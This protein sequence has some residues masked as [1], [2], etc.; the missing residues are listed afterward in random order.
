MVTELYGLPGAGKTTIIKNFTDGRATTVS[1]SK[2]LKRYIIQIAKKIVVYLPSSIQYKRRMNTIMK[3]YSEKSI[4]INRPKKQ[5]YNNIVMV[6]FGYK[7]MGNAVYMDEGL[8][9]RIITMAVNFG[10]TEDDVLA[11]IDLFEPCMR[12]VRSFYLDV[13]AEECLRS[14]MARDRHECE[15]DEFNKDTL[16]KYLRDYECYCLAICKSYQH[17]VIT[18]ENYE[19]MR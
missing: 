6:A 10:L 18:R 17:K 8:I 13:P 5:Y 3:S 16:K 2:G 11:L 9:H 7:N 4:Y 14:I 1:G 12:G 19:V 15:M